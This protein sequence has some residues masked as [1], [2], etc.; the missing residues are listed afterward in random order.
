MKAPSIRNGAHNPTKTTGIYSGKRFDIDYFRNLANPRICTCDNY[1]I[2]KSCENKCDVRTKTK[3]DYHT[4]LKCSIPTCKKR[5]HKEC[6]TSHKFIDINSI[7]SEDLLCMECESKQSEENVTWDQLKTYN[8]KKIE[9][10]G[11]QV[12]I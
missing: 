8:L 12:P 9:K 10:G 6:I 5:F 1:S 2:P 3:C 11:S 7:N 4:N